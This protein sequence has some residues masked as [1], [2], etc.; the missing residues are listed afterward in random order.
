MEYS[1]FNYPVSGSDPII[2][3]SA[4]AHASYNKHFWKAVNIKACRPKKNKKDPHVTFALYWDPIKAPYEGSWRL[5]WNFG[6]FKGF[7]ATF[8]RLIWRS[9]DW[10]NTKKESCTEGH[11]ISTVIKHGNVSLCVYPYQSFIHLLLSFL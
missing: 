3:T 10:A 5:L 11:G 4:Q 9:W 7:T 8:V 2:G 6:G 1:W